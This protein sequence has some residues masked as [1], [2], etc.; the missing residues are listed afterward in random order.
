M[1]ETKPNRP[2][3]RLP[4]G[5]RDRAASEIAA[6]RA[7]L[8]TIAKVY[9]SYGFEPLETPAFEFTDALGKFLP[10]LDR[11]NEGV[12]SLQDDDG[13][14]LSLRYDLTAPLAR[15]VAE[16]FQ[17]LPKPFRRYQVGSVWRNEKPGPGRFREFTQF[18]VDTVGSAAPAAD[19]EL[20]M[21]AADALEAVGLKRGE[22]LFKINSR[23]LLDVVLSTAEVDGS[24][25][26]AVL[27]A[28]DKFDRLGEQGVVQLLGDGRKD[29]S[30]DFSRG[31]GLDSK[32]TT[33]VMELLKGAGGR[34]ESTPAV[35]ELNAIL[36]LLRD[37]GYGEAQAVL[38]TS[39]IR[40]LEYYTGPVFEAQLTF[41]VSN[42]AGET[43]VFGSVAG[44]GRYDDLVARFTGQ[45]VP[46]TGISI[47]VSRLMSALKGRSESRL[48]PLVVV[49]A[50]DDVAGSFRM[51]AEL[52]AAGVR[53]EAYVGNRKF[54]DQL[55]Y[56]DR[57]N[58][59]IAVIEGSDERTKGEV[60][61]KDL[62]LG[63]ELSKSVESRG[64]WVK[65][66]AAQVSVKRAEL[67]AQV[68]QMLLRKG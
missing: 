52:R 10:D 20:V 16:N 27:R 48:S 5:F 59:A 19:A 29:E 1:S 68:R 62:A 9:E 47:G 6:E 64:E 32:Q 25:R 15:Y 12:F 21:M 35:Q 22:Y 37:A 41:P 67:V 31:A 28:I 60:T 42:E 39:I 45:Q 56:A 7:C 18:D 30:G 54:G 61:L 38:D 51:A 14:W 50:L 13:Q 63:A 2:K 65:G 11:P 33:L 36:Q 40:G 3:A 4:R 44:G 34:Y 55:K 46:A 58:A 23:K 66:R 17:H 43:I 49:L 26:G 53:V 24:R 8:E 57:R